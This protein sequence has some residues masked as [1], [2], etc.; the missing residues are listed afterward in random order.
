[1]GC[2]TSG[3]KMVDI[4]ERTKLFRGD[5]AISDNDLQRGDHV[6]VDAA[7]R[8][9]ILEAIEIRVRDLNASDHSH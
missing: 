6:T 1:M 2:A 3:I 8:G 5:A 7:L 9:E 4:V